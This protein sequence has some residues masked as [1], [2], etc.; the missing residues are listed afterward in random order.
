MHNGQWQAVA[1]TCD[2]CGTGWTSYFCTDCEVY[3]CKCC[4]GRH[5]NPPTPET[6][7]MGEC[8]HD[9]CTVLA[10]CAGYCL[11]HGLKEKKFRCSTLGCNR[12]AVARVLRSTAAMYFYCEN[13]VVDAF[14]N[15][16]AEEE[17]AEGLV[18]LSEDWQTLARTLQTLDETDFHGAIYYTFPSGH[19]V[20]FK[21]N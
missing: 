10:Y 20:K 2:W 14:K 21:G 9:G 13:C 16:E 18:K 4:W 15:E 12:A 3:I 8:E 7:N 6:S 1:R 17:A 11:M 5:A 19:R